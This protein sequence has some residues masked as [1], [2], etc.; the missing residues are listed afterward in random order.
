[1]PPHILKGLSRVFPLMFVGPCPIIVDEARFS[2]PWCSGEAV[3]W[4]QWSRPVAAPIS[5]LVEISQASC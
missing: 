3:Q 4:R 5:P 2:K 1:M